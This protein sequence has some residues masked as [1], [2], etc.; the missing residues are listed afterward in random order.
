MAEVR[1][2]GGG[3]DAS[4]GGSGSDGVGGAVVALTRSF[5]LGSSLCQVTMRI[6]SRSDWLSNSSR[7]SRSGLPKWCA[8]RRM[9][10]DSST[11]GS[12]LTAP[13]KTSS[14]PAWAR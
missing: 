9:Y 14:E 3:D 10:C 7:T 11:A 1:M 13:R 12:S 6:R 4:A 8:T 5:T 2:C